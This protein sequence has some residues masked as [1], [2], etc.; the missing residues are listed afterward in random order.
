MAARNRPRAP[1]KDEGDAHEERDLWVKIIR[2]LQ[3]LHR[4]SRGVQDLTAQIA[5]EEERIAEIGRFKL[6]YSLLLR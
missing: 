5:Q 3:E 2:E 4:M 1:L 6:H